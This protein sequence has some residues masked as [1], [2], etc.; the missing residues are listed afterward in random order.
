M[1]TYLFTWNP[2]KWNWTDLPEAVYKVNTGEDYYDYWNC[3]NTKRIE[4]GDRF[5]LMKLGK[6]PKGIIGA[7][8][9][10][11]EPYLRPHWEE[12]KANKGKMALRADLLFTT[13]CETPIIDEQGLRTKPSLELFDW[14]PRS[15]GVSVPDNISEAVF[16]IIE[17]EI[18][19]QPERLSKAQLTKLKEGMPSKITINSYDRSPLARQQCVEHY[20][21][22]CEVC[23]FAFEKK[24]GELGK[25]FIHVHHLNQLAD[26]CAEYEID[27]INDLRPVCANCHAMLHKK[28]PAYSIEEIKTRIRT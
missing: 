17:K 6:H 12:V 5:L 25:G 7:G 13:L 18:G 23:G 2:Q 3:G 21:T 4:T 27:P 24:Y 1:N 26:I 20:G 8:Q 10:I 14:F 22:D 11:S 9:I 16:K 15:S 28:R 19:L